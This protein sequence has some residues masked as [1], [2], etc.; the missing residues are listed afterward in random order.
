MAMIAIGGAI[1]TGLFVGSGTALNTGGPVG[2]WIAYCIMAFMVYSMMVALGEMAAL[3]PVAGGFTHYAS[4][5]VDE[6][7]GFAVGVNYWYSYAVTIPSESL[8]L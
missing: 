1:G 4:R 3:F 7:L 8:G 5:F 6:S 2:V